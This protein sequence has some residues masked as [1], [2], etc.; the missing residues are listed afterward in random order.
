MYE[1]QLDLQIFRNVTST[2]VEPNAEDILIFQFAQMLVGVGKDFGE[3]K[4]N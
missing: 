2:F 3:L 1:H 4:G